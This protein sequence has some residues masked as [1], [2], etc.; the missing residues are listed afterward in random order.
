V[1]VP[2]GARV[3]LRRPTAPSRQAFVLETVRHPG[4]SVRGAAVRRLREAGLS[5]FEPWAVDLSGTVAVLAADLSAPVPDGLRP[6]GNGEAAGA[7]AVPE[8]TVGFR[9]M[10]VADL[11]DLVRWTT[12]PHVARWWDRESVDLET[13]QR[14]YGPRLSGVDPTRMWVFEVNGRSVGFAQDYLIG[15][16][17]DY[18]LLTARPDAVGFDYA[19]GDP[20]WVG[21]GIGTRLLWEYLRDVVRPH[22]PTVTTF[23][24]APDHRNGASLRM[25]DKL[26]FERGL[27]FD[28]PQSGGE[29]STVVGCSLDVPRV[30]GRNR[31]PRH[32]TDG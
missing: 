9:P 22:Y 2:R 23:F 29:V 5:G 13:A 1:S 27:W 7:L 6:L 4:E 24:A 15:D 28:E 19:V 20:A 8:A 26:G 30:L 32:V 12:A 25:L 18:A 14:H 11:P 3:V 17:P 10:S 31:G 21:R 16:H